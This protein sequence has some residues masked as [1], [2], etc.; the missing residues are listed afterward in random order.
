MDQIPL[1]TLRTAAAALTWA[2]FWL[3]ILTA[4]IGWL[5]TQVR[6]ESARRSDV[7][8]ATAEQQAAQ[9]YSKAATA[10]ERAES[11]KSE[12][13]ATRERLVAAERSLETERSAR[14]ELE[15]R[16]AP[17]RISDNQVEKLRQSLANEVYVG[18]KP[19]T[20]AVFATTETGEAQIFANSLAL[21][22]E[23]CGFIINR[24]T[25]HYG[26]PYHL[27]GVG[28]L[29]SDDPGALEHGVVFTNSLNGVGVSS[30]LLPPRNSAPSHGE[31][32]FDQDTYR[33]N[34]G[35]SLMVGDRPS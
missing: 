13:L 1:S 21:A 9:A 29:I 15:R 32:E 16:V 12:N 22:M 7:R 30:V 18:D 27:Q 5:A 24:N 33:F 25:V 10:N 34:R 8:V 20:V 2:T 28:V 3:A 4:G 35:I 6:S 11:L 14:L 17:R 26:K 23:R 31:T 19:I